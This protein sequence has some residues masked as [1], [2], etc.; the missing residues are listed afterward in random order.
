MVSRCVGYRQHIVPVVSGGVRESREFAG[1]EPG[2]RT[3]RETTG[4]QTAADTPASRAASSLGKPQAIA[5]QNRGRASGRATG[6]ARR[7]H[8][9]VEQPDSDLR[10]RVPIATRLGRVDN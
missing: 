8:H 9:R 10:V 5:A 4:H 2:G 3:L 6:G 1:A 7:P